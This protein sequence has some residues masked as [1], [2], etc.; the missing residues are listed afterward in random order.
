MS[1]F[2]IF[3]PLTFLYLTL[4]STLFSSLPVPDLPLLI[5]FYMA[6][7][8]PSIDGVVLAFLLGY[9]DDAFSGGI[10]GS[11]SFSLIVIYGATRLSAGRVQF[12]TPFIRA[13]GAGIAAFIKGL[14]MYAILRLTSLNAHFTAGVFL[15][16]VITGVFAPAMITIFTRLT[17]LVSRDAFKDNVN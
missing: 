12:S 17:A 4:K 8:K 10:I 16:A 13:G 1:D 11:T 6:Y 5:V 9:I 2:I 3:L 7:R 14:V 15:E